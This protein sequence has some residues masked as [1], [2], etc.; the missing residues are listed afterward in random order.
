ME[1]DKNG[2]P[3]T[4]SWDECIDSLRKESPEFWRKVDYVGQQMTKYDGLKGYLDN[5]EEIDFF[6]GLSWWT[7]CRIDIQ[8]W[9]Y[10]KWHNFINWVYKIV[11]RKDFK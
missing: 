9:F 1:Y 10:I 3:L 6:E 7:K 2:K 11:H 5:V 8:C 4:I